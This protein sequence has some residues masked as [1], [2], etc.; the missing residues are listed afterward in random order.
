MEYINSV[1]KDIPPILILTGIQ[2][3]TSWFNNNLDDDI[4]ITT[5]KTG[6]TND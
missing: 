1:G 3:L 6:Y 2:Q 4:A 5:A